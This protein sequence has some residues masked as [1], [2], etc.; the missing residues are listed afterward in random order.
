MGT[1]LFFRKLSLGI[2]ATIVLS[3]AGGSAMADEVTFTG[4]TN[5]CFNCA[6]TPNTSA[7]QTSSL[8]ALMFTNAQFNDTTVGGNVAFG[9]NP[10]PGGT[11][12]VN[13]FGSF[14]LAPAMGSTYTG[15]TFTLQV[16]FLAP[17]GITGGSAQVYSATLTGATN[18]TGN[19]GVLIDFDNTPMVFTFAN[20]TTTGTFTLTITDVTVN[21]GQTSSIDAFIRSA[22][23]TTSTVPEPTSMMLL[24]TGLIGVAGFARKRFVKRRNQ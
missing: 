8:F 10:T 12:N 6:S 24:G 3:V 7:T 19:G 14:S 22:S 20:G 23:Q 18:A 1:G 5:G 16:S 15:N 9:G 4:Y 13:N 11:Q 21:P 2:L 17:V